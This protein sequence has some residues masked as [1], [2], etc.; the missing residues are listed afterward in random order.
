MH[1]A[2]EDECKQQTGTAL[3][4]YTVSADG[5]VST[6]GADTTATKGN[7]AAVVSVSAMAVGGIIGAGMVLMAL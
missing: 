5:T 7:G 1:T 2:Y 3:A 4:S 6:S